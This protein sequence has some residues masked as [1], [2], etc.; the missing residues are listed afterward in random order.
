MQIFSAIW[1]FDATLIHLGEVIVLVNSA[2]AGD[3]P[4]NSK[5]MGTSDA[6]LLSR[7]SVTLGKGMKCILSCGRAEAC[8]Q[9]EKRSPFYSTSKRSYMAMAAVSIPVLYYK[10]YSFLC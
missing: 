4:K 5:S 3:C 2:I 7:Y 10:Y 1:L 9:K 8:N 6:V